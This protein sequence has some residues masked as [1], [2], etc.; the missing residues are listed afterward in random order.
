[1]TLDEIK[2]TSWQDIFGYMEYDLIEFIEDELAS[3]FNKG[4][5]EDNDHDFRRTLYAIGR[6]DS[7]L[8][9][10]SEAIKRTDLPKATWHCVT[11]YG[12]YHNDWWQ[13]WWDE[14]EIEEEDTTEFVIDCIK[15]YVS[16][17]LSDLTSDDA[18]YRFLAE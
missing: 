2:K 7:D 11:K 9:N 14:D 12:E 10:L 18:F 13:D 1:M 3:E 4:D 17:H 6:I 5:F 8:D 15:T 16:D